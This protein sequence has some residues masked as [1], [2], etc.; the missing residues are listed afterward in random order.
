MMDSAQAAR[1]I[2]SLREE[3]KSHELEI[4]E[5]IAGHFSGLNVGESEVAGQYVV[6]ASPNVRFDPSLARKELTEEEF[7]SI[8]ETVPSSKKA[9]ELLAPATYAKLQRQFQP[10]IKVVDPEE[11]EN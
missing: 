1:R 2:R 10:T 5:L 11:E 3:I 9:K 8:L 7:S 6:R 4:K